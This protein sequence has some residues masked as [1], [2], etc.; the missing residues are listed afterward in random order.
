MDQAVTLT[1]ADGVGHIQLN[2]PD[3]ANTIDMPLASGLRAAAA[4]VAAAYADAGV[5]LQR[6]D[7]LGEWA[8]LVVQKPA[9]E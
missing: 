1:V 4:A 5:P 9:G 7:D 2:R 6:R 8:T 3:A